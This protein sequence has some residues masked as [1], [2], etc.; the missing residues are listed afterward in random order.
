MV[1]EKKKNKNKSKTVF[2]RGREVLFLR[3]GRN[4]FIFYV[5]L[6]MGKVSRFPILR[7]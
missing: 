6:L 4:A 2:F 7:Y 1:I 5:C 3:R